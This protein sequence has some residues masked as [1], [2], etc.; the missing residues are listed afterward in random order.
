MNCLKKLFNK[1][2]YLISVVTL[3]SCS[4]NSEAIQQKAK[5]TEQTAQEIIKAKNI[6]H[7]PTN[8]QANCSWQNI[9]FTI[10]N[11]QGNN[12][13]QGGNN[14]IIFDPKSKELDFKVSLG[15]NHKIYTK[16]CLLYTS[17]SPR[18]S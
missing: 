1:T 16:D 12:D 18:D 5:S 14:V 2:L 4:G 11:N 6:K 7:D 9:K 15:L 3:F 13:E 17:P 8:K 10:S